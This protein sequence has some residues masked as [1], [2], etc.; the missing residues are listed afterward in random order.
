VVVIYKITSPSGKVYIGQTHDWCKREKGYRRLKCLGQPHLYNS[1]LKYGYEQHISE[2]VEEL[3][4]NINQNILDEREVFWWKYY[5]DL[6]FEMLNL[7]YPGRAGKHSEESRLKMSN[8]NQYKNKKIPEELRQKLI[9]GNIGRGKSKEE[10][11]KIQK[12]R[13]GFVLSVE[14]RE[15]IRQTLRK[16]PKNNRAVLMLDYY[17]NPVREFK[18]VLQIKEQLNWD[19]KQ[20]R[21]VLHNK[22]KT[23]KGYKWKYKD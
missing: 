7:K 9:Q 21:E 13:I 17:G 15:K 4:S 5:K 2:I 10:I 1:F 6:G 12:G 20:I 16:L 3:N 19:T 18:N 22:A 23:A 8:S 11:E 14:A